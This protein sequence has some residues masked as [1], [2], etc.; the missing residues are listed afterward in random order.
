[1]DQHSESLQLANQKLSDEIDNKK[2]IVIPN[3]SVHDITDHKVA[4]LT[5]NSVG[6]KDLFDN[7]PQGCAYYQVLF[8]EAGSPVDLEFLQVNSAY[9]ANIGR[10]RSELVGQHLTKIFPRLSEMS[11]PWLETYLKVALFGEPVNLT[12]RLDYS[13]KWYSIFAYSSQHGY[14]VEISEDI[15]ERK[16][17]EARIDQHI[18]AL[19][20]TNQELNTSQSRYRGLLDHMHSI[21]AYYRVITDENSRPIDLEFAEVNPVFEMRTGLKIVDVVGTRLPMVVHGIDK[22]YL[23]QLLGEVALTGQP[24]ILEQYFE[25]IDTWYQV[26]AYSPES[27]YVASI[28]EDITEQKKVAAQ[29]IVTQKQVAL[30]ER[31]ASLG[32]LAAGVAHEI[33]QP[34]QALKI[35][36]DGMIYWYDKGKETRVEKVIENCRGISLQAGYITAIVEWMLDSV[37]RAWSDTPEA[38][39]LNNMITQ[40]VKLV[41]ERLKIHSVQLR[42]NICSALPVIWGD[43]SRLKEIVIIILVNALES[44]DC[45][46]QTSKEIVLSTSCL[47][48]RAVIEISNNGP[49]IPDDIIEKIFEPFFSSSRA[50]AKL[51]MGLAIVKSVVNA[52]NGTIQVSNLNQQVMFRIKFPLYRQEV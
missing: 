24:I 12:Q 43:V 33:N 35:M 8:D 3:H 9:E 38:V 46:D 14:L 23:I 47:E 25:K 26:S 20:E 45:V 44:L 36:A 4:K 32:A 52:H 40:A 16:R 42:E 37:N 27:G 7:M 21:F 50:D 51:G 34:L 48:E 18:V 10:S 28:L 1:V 22:A 39:D 29:E 49:A 5:T 2:G 41:Q 17:N 31:A 6:Y 19:T 15:S 13:D 11:F 30:I